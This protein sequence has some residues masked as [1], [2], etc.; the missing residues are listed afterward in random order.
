MA[1][2]GKA[3]VGFLDG[4]VVLTW[5]AVDRRTID[6]DALR[7]K[8]PKIAEQVTRVSQSRRFTFKTTRSILDED[9]EEFA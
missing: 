9:E 1:F 3:E 5:S 2:L 4:K 7:A 8:H 6:A